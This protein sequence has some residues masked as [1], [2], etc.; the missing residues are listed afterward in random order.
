MKS[1]FILLLLCSSGWVLAQE[2][3]D[4]TSVFKK[5]V[6]ENTEID[7]LT[8]VYTQDG[9]NSSVTGGIGSEK[10]EDYATNINVS[11]PL[12]D[13]DILSITAKISAYT[14]ASSNNANPFNR[15]GEDGEYE[16]EEGGDEGFRFGS[17]WVEISGA[18]I[19]DVWSNVS[20]GYSHS[21]DDRNTILTAN[22]SVS[23]EYDYSSV[24]FG[25]GIT[26]LSN[27]KNTEVGI[28]ASV[29]LDN[30]RPVYPIENWASNN[31]GGNLNSGFFA[32]RDILDANGAVIDK[33]GAN[34]WQPI[35]NTLIQDNGRNTFVLSL[36]FSQIL[37]KNSQ[38][39]F[40][41]DIT[42][43]KGW[44]ANPLNRVYFADR[45]NFFIGNPSSIPN[46]TS[47][48]NQ[49]VFQLAD[50]IER[51]PS[52]RLKVPIGVRY[53]Y[54]INEFLIVRT[55][56]RYYFDTWGINSN[57]F[58]IEL[59]I[60]LG[61]KF[62]LY[63]N[64]RFYNQTAVDYFGSFEQLL[65]TSNF[66]TSDYDLS[67]FTSNQFGSGIKYTDKLTKGHLGK[68]RLKNISLN[69][70][71]YKRNTGLKAHIVTFGTKFIIE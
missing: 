32:G 34:R 14:S 1:F 69:Y 62:T 39:S 64:F 13:D 6:L 48:S 2:Q 30:W 21:S 22:A 31:V 35:N 28:S 41:S 24:G 15:T 53:N 61:E 26:K 20:L 3:K 10:L 50:D 36:N 49:D 33:N 12:N 42:Y 58:N 17:P 27:S 60:K 11:I 55:Y 57:T 67:K 4:T 51:L 25:G 16:E 46:Y 56:Y 5:R 37:N 40:S 38:I 9:N 44:L 29:F 54:Y 8:S 63:P 68:F 19:T 43:Q 59:P 71:Y 23:R 18:S 70:N 65:S 47:A 45:D 52:N 7:I 66:Y